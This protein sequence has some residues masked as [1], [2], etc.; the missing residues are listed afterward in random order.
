MSKTRN[1]ISQREAVR[2]R[3]ELKE[4]RNLR[5]RITSEWTGQRIQLTRPSESVVASLR[6]ARQLGYAVLV[7]VQDDGCLSYRAWKP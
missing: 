4:L 5:E 7:T 1:P 3:R 6:T 2:N